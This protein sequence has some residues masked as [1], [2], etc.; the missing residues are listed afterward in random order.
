MTKTEKT[1]FYDEKLGI[2][3]YRFKSIVQPFPNHL[4][5]YY[6]IGLIE[7]GERKLFC[8]NREYT[9]RKG[10]ILLFNPNDTHGCMQTGN[11]AFDYSGINIPKKVMM[12]LVRD[13]T[14]Q[15]CELHFS[16]NVI[17]DNE[18]KLY[19]ET[20]ISAFTENGRDFEKEEMFLTVLS[21]LITH[22][23]MLAEKDISDLN[24]QT[25]RICLYINR[26]YK[27]HISL[28]DLSNYS[29][30]SKS[31]LLR[32]FTK[33]KG[34][35]PYRYLQSVRIEKAKA[36]LENGIPPAEAALESGFSDQSHF[37]NFFNMYIGIS[38][39][40]YRRMFLKSYGGRS[41]E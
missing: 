27:E 40:A 17:R 21:L 6:V 13:I 31:T 32:A 2:E 25:N 34:I 8:K 37:T 20:F 33:T 36:L 16:Q 12:S 14:T 35:T 26:H 22:Y 38:P 10:D 39:A 9:V 11:G 7:N 1:V 19:L 28:D 23:G 5:N 24:V 30:L 41:N 4:H 3:L 15:V 18:L 29:N